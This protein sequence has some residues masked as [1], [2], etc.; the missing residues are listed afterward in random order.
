MRADAASG[1]RA[2]RVR[3]TVPCRQREGTVIRWAHGTVPP[4]DDDDRVSLSQRMITGQVAP[5]SCRASRTWPPASKSPRRTR[6][7]A[8]AASKM[9]RQH[10]MAQSVSRR[11][12]RR[13]GGARC[14]SIRHLRSHSAPRRLADPGDDGSDQQRRRALIFDLVD[15]GVV[16]D[17]FEVVPQLT[18][19]IRPV[20][21]E[22]VG[23]ASRLV[24]SP[25]PQNWS[26]WPQLS[27]V[28]A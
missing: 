4:P 14:V 23:P 16:D 11:G 15:Y 17:L 21:A 13:D 7:H 9:C 6:S 22:M 10:R 25:G 28:D 5:P 12:V 3:H 1:R 20:R 18:E 24:A 27:T 26:G 19:E 8:S 2:S